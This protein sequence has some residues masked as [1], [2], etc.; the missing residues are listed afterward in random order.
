M[1][2]CEQASPR[3]G[4][5]RSSR[6]FRLLKEL[7][8]WRM[9]ES[10]RPLADRGLERVQEI[11]SIIFEMKSDAPTWRELPQSAACAEHL[12]QSDSRDSRCDVT[13]N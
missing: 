9:M 1:C 2:K 5:A 6:N 13:F 10:W 7:S 3:V 12:A 4:T 8:L 11:A